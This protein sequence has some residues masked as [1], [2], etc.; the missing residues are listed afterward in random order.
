MKSLR[1]LGMVTGY[2]TSG[3]GSLFSS[4]V[5]SAYLEKDIGESCEPVVQSILDKTPLS[6]EISREIAHSA[7]STN[8]LDSFEFYRSLTHSPITPEDARR[9]AVY[10][11][12]KVIEHIKLP[13]NLYSELQ[14]GI[15][16]CTLKTPDALSTFVQNYILTTPLFWV[17]MTIAV[18]TPLGLY[19]GLRWSKP[20][21]KDKQK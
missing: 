21:E 5:A 20:S 7:I 18:G 2:L 10:I 19:L 1:V 8:S 16:K 6:S 9:A 3:I 13:D 11:G 4:V 12:G 17:G 14:D 15:I